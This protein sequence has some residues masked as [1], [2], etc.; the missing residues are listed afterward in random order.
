MELDAT[1]G[2][3]DAN[4]FLDVD[5]AEDLLTPSAN[6]E[7]WSGADD[8]AALLMRATR[9]MAARCWTGAATTA[10]QALPWPRTGMVNRNG[11]TVPDD[12]IPL[13]LEIATAE[14]AAL[15]A[16]PVGATSATDLTADNDAVTQGIKRV[17]AGPVEVEWKDKAAT[18][19]AAVVLPTIITDY[20][21]ASWLCGNVVTVSPFLF[22][23][24]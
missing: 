12:E 5:R 4:A 11:F 8:Q 1:V 21:V 2:G 23:A 15:M 7:A 10:E 14:L 18:A 13:E 22:E 20:L 17:K 16:P 9:W 24:L 19:A 3:P 6:Y